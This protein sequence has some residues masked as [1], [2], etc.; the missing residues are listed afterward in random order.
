LPASTTSSDVPVHGTCDP[1]FEN[2]REVFAKCVASSKEVGAAIAF[3][4]DGESVVDL[5]GGYADESC[6]REWERDTIV[7]TY[8]TTKGMTALCA[9]RLI[10]RGLIRL[11]EPVAKHWPEFAQKGK[12]KVPFRW[13]LSHQVGLPAIRE[14][15]PPETLYD[16]DAMC[17]ALASTEPWWEPG[18]QH[19][20]HPVTYGFLVGEVI[21]RVTGKTVGQMFRE[22]VA[23]PL[24]ADFH[25][26]LPP[27]HH[28]RVS[29]LLGSIA[30]AKP[31]DGSAPAPVKIKGPL[32]DFMRD[33]ADSTTM[34]G[35]AF[36]NPRIRSGAHN[37]AEW[38]Q[39]EIPAANGHGNARALARVYGA[40][41]CGGEVDGVR[42]LEP[43][44]IVQARTEQASGP[45]QTLANMPMR[46]GLGY[47]LR[48]EFMPFSPSE[49]AFGHPG[50]G[51][52]IGMADPDAG[53]GFGYVMNKMGM[54][55]V[56]GATGFAVLKAFFEAR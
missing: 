42:L 1:R 40:L 52:S 45:D 9:H 20:Y 54:G 49:N 50:A 17:A 24:G 53:V 55:L 10:E 23:E 44:S 47:M 25:I 46:F 16:W 3:T 14:P 37:T 30:P 34:V 27:E 33:M 35:A 32:G 26:G 29:D 12:E 13:L 41:A 6:T 31:K 5:W 8:S 56:G 18:T 7:N 2:V 48:S 51:G 4:L 43:Q 21:R 36:N 38:R 15:L 39:A 11:D 22:E 19:G 28:H